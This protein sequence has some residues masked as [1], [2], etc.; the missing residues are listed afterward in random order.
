MTGSAQLLMSPLTCTGVGAIGFLCAGE[1]VVGGDR[2]APGAP[3]LVAAQVQRRLGSVE[4][5]GFLRCIRAPRVCN[6]V[7]YA[8]LL[9]VSGES[10]WQHVLMHGCHAGRRDLCRGILDAPPRGMKW[11]L[12]SFTDP[13]FICM[14]HDRWCSS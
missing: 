13:G 3:S 4:A 12:R 2:H 1:V 10:L 11:Q 7:L 9:R 5:L 6:K 14:P 8:L